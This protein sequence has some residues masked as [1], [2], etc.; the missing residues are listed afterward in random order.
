M[1][2]SA[3]GGRSFIA[4]LEPLG[5]DLVVAEGETLIEAGRHRGY[6]W[7]S[8]CGGLAACSVCF[9]RVLEGRESLSVPTE[10]ERDA[11]QRFRGIDV[12]KQ[13]DVRLACQLSLRGDAIIRKV[14]VWRRDR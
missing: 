1:G 8:V 6:A 11:L 7:P 10:K 13:P 9:V 14:G 12:K 4:R 3:S 2:P 5:V